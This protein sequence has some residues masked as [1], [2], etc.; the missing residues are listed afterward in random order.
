MMEKIARGDRNAARVG[1]GR[2]DQS[3][4]Q[5]ESDCCSPP[6]ASRI[7]DASNV[8]SR[9]RRRRMPMH[10]NHAKGHPSINDSFSFLS[11]SSFLLF[12]D[13]TSAWRDW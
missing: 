11:F 8:S 13:R 2:R 3:T 12:S 4:K 7:A 10:A 1:Y 9:W 6:F 5:L